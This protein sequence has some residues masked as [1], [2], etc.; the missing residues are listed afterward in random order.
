MRIDWWTL[1]LQTVNLLILLW[2]LSRFLFRPVAD[3]IARRQQDASD[4]LDRAAEKKAEADGLLKSAGEERDRAAAERA[5]AADEGRKAAEKERAA[6][7]VAARREAEAKEANA[8][9]D[10]ARRQEEEMDRLRLM[11]SGLATDI[12]AKLLGEPAGRLPFSAFVERFEEGLASLDDEARASIA[13]GGGQVPVVF[14]R[15]PAPEEVEQVEAA[16]ARASGSEVKIAQSVDS[17]LIAGFWMDAAEVT[18]DASLKA[19]L[20]RVR[21]GL[22]DHAG[23]G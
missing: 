5:A 11:A 20:D 7:L 2:I 19:D 16:L 21:N 14:A 8:R 10:I 15:P 6:I 23:E 3:M 18:V 13:K 1:G 12:A 4:L 9:E 22:T 17:S